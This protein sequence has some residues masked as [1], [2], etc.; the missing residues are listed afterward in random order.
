MAGRRAKGSIMRFRGKGYRL[1]G[2]ADPQNTLREDWPLE[3]PM[4]FC[5]ADH[6]LHLPARIFMTLGRFS[7]LLAGTREEVM[8][9]V[10]PLVLDDFLQTFSFPALNVLPPGELYAHARRLYPPLHPDEDDAIP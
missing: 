6:Y 4:I 7:L 3:M 2:V 5:R 9:P 8:L 10:F 1:W